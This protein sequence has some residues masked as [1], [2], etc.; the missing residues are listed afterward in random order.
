MNSAKEMDDIY[1]YGHNDINHLLDD[2][3]KDV[4]L[5]F[6]L[7]KHITPIFNSKPYADNFRLAIEGNQDLMDI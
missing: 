6:K 1:N 5:K 7:F 2:T 3:I 4:G